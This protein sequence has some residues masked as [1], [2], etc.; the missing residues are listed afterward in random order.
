MKTM[1]IRAFFRFYWEKQ[2]ELLLFMERGDIPGV[3]QCQ[4]HVEDAIAW[5][6]QQDTRDENPHG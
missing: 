5:L 2:Q 3:V 1:L 4:G 6:T